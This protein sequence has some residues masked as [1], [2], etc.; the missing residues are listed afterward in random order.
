MSDIKTTEE[1]TVKDAPETTE[2][3]EI[4]ETPE[5][6]EQPKEDDTPQEVE[7]TE[8]PLGSILQDDQDKDSEDSNKPVDF[9]DL[10]KKERKDKR[11]LEARLKKLEE[12]ID[13]GASDDDITGDMDDI[14][15]EFNVDKSFLNKLEKSIEKKLEKRFEEQVDSKLAPLT[16]RERQMKF[17]K[18]FNSNWELALQKVPEFKDIA[19]KSS[20]MQLAKLPENGNKVLSKII[21]ETYSNSLGGR[22]TLETTT[23]RG[24]AEPNKVDLERTKTDHEYR[25]SVLR[26]PEL[27][28]QYNENLAQRVLT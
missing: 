13:N 11:Q 20:I 8:Q 9:K 16:E 24:G 1:Q 23:P 14:A 27:K 21:E 2:N 25:K 18:A 22:A 4:T 28:K 15:D 10:Y 19:N 5:T 3:P 12:N 6:T 7:T 26:D 17:E